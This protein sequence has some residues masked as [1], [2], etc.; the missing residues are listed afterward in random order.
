MGNRTVEIPR[1][2]YLCAELFPEKQILFVYPSNNNYG[3]IGK[4][5]RLCPKCASLTMY[6]L[7]GQIHGRFIRKYKGIEQQR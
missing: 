7:S 1:E 2:C 5:L 6:H 3:G 4:A